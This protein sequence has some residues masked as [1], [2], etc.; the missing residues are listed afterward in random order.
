MKTSTRVRIVG[1]AAALM[2]VVPMAAP[3]NAAL[4]SGKLYEKCQEIEHDLQNFMC[5]TFG[6]CF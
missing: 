3:A 6:K 4:C 5:H 2:A 1:A